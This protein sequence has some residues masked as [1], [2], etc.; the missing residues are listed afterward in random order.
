MTTNDVTYHLTPKSKHS[1]NSAQ[2]AIQTWRDYFLSGMAST[3]TDFPLSQWCKLFEQGNIT[4]N[5]FRSS[6]LNPKLSAYAQFF[7]AFKYQK[8]PFPPPGMKLMAHVLPIDHHLFGTHAIKGFS[9]CFAM[10]HHRYFK[11]FIPSTGGV[12]IAETVGLFPHGSLKLPIP[13]KY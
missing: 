10:E 7:G 5:L 13:S 1:R 11:I 4:L 12:H 3:Y 2:K 9:V 8:T 6:R